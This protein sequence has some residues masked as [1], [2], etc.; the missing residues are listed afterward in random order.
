MAQ[1]FISSTNSRRDELL[2]YQLQGIKRLRELRKAILA[3]DTGLGKTVQAL[4]ASEFPMLVIA[5]RQALKTWESEA[6]EWLRDDISVV[7]YRGNK[8]Q[9]QKLLLGM[10]KCLPKIVV[11]T[12]AMMSELQKFQRYWKTIVFDESHTLRNR[13]TKTLYPVAKRFAAKNMFFLTADPVVKGAQDYWTSLNM[14]APYKFRSYWDFVKRYCNVY[15]DA[16]SGSLVV[17][18]TKAETAQELADLLENYMVRQTEASVGL[19]LPEKRRQLVSVEMTPEQQ[20]WYRQLT[21]DMLHD[22]ENGV[23]ILTENEMTKMLRLRQLLVHPGLLG[24]QGTSAS[25]RAVLE[26]LE[27][28]HEPI[29]VFTPFTAAIPLFAHDLIAAG[30]QVGMI[31]G[32]MTD[33]QLK[34]TQEEFA[35]G[36]KRVLLASL[37]MSTSWT[38][39]GCRLGYV[40]GFDWTPLTHNQAEGRIVGGLRRIGKSGALIRYMVHEGSIE[41]HILAILT[42]KV[43]WRTLAMDPERL[44]RPTNGA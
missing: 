3:A 33:R 32:Q 6:K 31:H 7:L 22:V 41:S 9:R 21:T 20:K 40:L 17:E 28:L 5:P 26:E 2:P 23:L 8:K 34:D 35:K 37:L 12:Y 18:G 16:W 14:I 25:W 15:E 24:L 4:Y 42:E 1:L 36:G 29:V 39:H 44:L 10:Q 19:Q 27:T 13:K 11:T 43:T 38:A 30:W